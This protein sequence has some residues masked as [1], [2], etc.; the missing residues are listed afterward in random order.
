[1]RDPQWI[2]KERAHWEKRTLWPSVGATF[3]QGDRKSSKSEAKEDVL[4]TTTWASLDHTIYMAARGNLG[5]LGMLVSDPQ[6][7]RDNL[8]TTPLVM[9]DHSPIWVRYSGKEEG[10]LFN[11]MEAT[12]YKTRRSLKY[13]IENASDQNQ[14]DALQS[15]L[16]DHQAKNAEFGDQMVRNI[17]SGADKYRLTWIDFQTVT[18]WFEPGVLPKGGLLPSI[19]LVPSEFHACAGSL[20]KGPSCCFSETK[21]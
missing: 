13:Q 3:R 2:G 20:L 7:F 1:M 12:S 16:E 5:D 4:V 17:A 10:C 9:F 14:K 18:S 19:L 11:L 21:L 8:A 6:G 15:Q